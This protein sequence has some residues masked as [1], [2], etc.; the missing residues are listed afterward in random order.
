MR[1]EQ[2][3]SN[4][5]IYRAHIINRQ[6]MSMKIV[7][8]KAA[9]GYH[10]SDERCE[11]CEMPLLSMNGDKVM[12][13]VCP[14]LTKLIQIKNKEHVQ[15]QDDDARDAAETVDVDSVSRDNEISDKGMDD[16]TF[17]PF[18]DALADSTVDHTEKVNMCQSIITTTSVYLTQSFLLPLIDMMNAVDDQH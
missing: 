15:S 2:I 5:K 1:L 10:I 7:A 8:K 4:S 12:C 18:L 17:R 14:A 13:K 11:L 3:Y 6:K 9:E 16:D